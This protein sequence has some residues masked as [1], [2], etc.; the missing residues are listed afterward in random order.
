[1]GMIPSTNI[2]AILIGE[3]WASEITTKYVSPEVYRPNFD[4]T[5]LRSFDYFAKSIF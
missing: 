5:S 2:L 1:M 3:V 4:R